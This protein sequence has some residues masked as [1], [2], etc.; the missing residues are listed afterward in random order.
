MKAAIRVR[1][2]L[3][4]QK[5]KG[6]QR[7]QEEVVDQ[8]KKWLKKMNRAEFLAAVDQTDAYREP[9]TRIASINP[10]STQEYPLTPCLHWLARSDAD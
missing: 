10:T 4:N 9:K 2:E 7:P 8:C 5:D 6:S 1:A 3:P